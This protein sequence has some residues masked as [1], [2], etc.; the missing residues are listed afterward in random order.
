MTIQEIMT[1]TKEDPTL[2]ELANCLK[3][4]RSIKNNK[5]LKEF[6]R[7]FNELCIHETGIILRK[8]RMVLP[9]SLRARAVN[10]AHEGHLGIVMCKRLLRNRC[11]WPT[12]D[13][14][15]EVKVN[16]CVACQANT[17]TTHHEP[18]IPTKMPHD[19]LG[20]T[21]IDFSTCS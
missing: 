20:L 6:N 1:A 7:V 18:M 4:M 21:S 17:D 11:W 16:D 14:D 9:Q 2:N 19:R 3:K 15:I 8:D 5:T 10:Y 13:K 12:M